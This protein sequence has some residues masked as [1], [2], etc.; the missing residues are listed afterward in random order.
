MQDIINH[1]KKNQSDIFAEWQ[2]ECSLRAAARELPLVFPPLIAEEEELDF[3]YRAFYFSGRKFDFFKILFNNLQN[4]PALK[5]LKEAPDYVT[6]DFWSFLPWYV[7]KQRPAPEKLHF[8]ISLYTSENQQNIEPLINTIN[9]ETVKYLLSKTANPELRDLLKKRLECLVDLRE[10]NLYDFEKTS[11]T[12][13][14]NTIYGDKIENILTAINLLQDTGIDNYSDPYG[15]ERFMKFLAAADKVYECGMVE[16]CLALLIDLYEDYQRKNRLVNVLDDEKVYR[17][18][19]RLLRKSLNIYAL[20][21]HP[22]EAGR[23]VE[24]TY[25]QYFPLINIDQAA[26][27]YLSI[28]TSI[29]EGFNNQSKGILYEIA[30]KGQNLKQ[31]RPLD[32]DFR[33]PE[34]GVS[35]IAWSNTMKVIDQKKSSL[36]HE[37]FVI[38]EYHRLLNL[39]GIINFDHEQ[40][41]Q[42]IETYMQFWCWL[43]VRLFMNENINNQMAPLLG[44]KVRSKANR[45]VEAIHENSHQQLFNEIRNRPD[46]FKARGSALKRLLL[47]ADFLGVLK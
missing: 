18:F 45:I 27:I 30:A 34:Q 37:S 46:L 38:I 12:E 16:D 33:N 43:P 24:N 3:F 40:A 39:L 21:K 20:I 10:K 29:L 42:M 2:A 15:G 1:L 5:W 36:P 23:Y 32:F 47:S 9:Y 22:L 4:T 13:K 8:I 26:L 17:G 19:Y 14:F 41:E 11:K 7:S 6:Q 35:R 31:I 28:Y 25:K 44:K